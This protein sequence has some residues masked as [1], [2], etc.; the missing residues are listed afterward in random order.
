MFSPCSRCAAPRCRGGLRRPTPHGPQPPRHP[1]AT[2][3]ARRRRRPPEMRT[4]VVTARGNPDLSVGRDQGKTRPAGGRA[5][6]AERRMRARPNG[7]S[8]RRSSGGDAPTKSAPRSGC[9]SPTASGSPPTPRVIAEIAARSDV[10]SVRSDAS[11]WSRTSHPRSAN[12]ATIGAPSVWAD[13]RT[14]QGAVVAVL[15]SGVDMAHPDLASGFRGGATGW[16]DP[17]GQRPRRWTSAATA[18]LWPE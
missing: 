2:R 3:S 10:V 16:F 9:G 12:Q 1:L 4:V 5:Q 14:G 7:D 13:G 18:L 11:T 8:G 6:R 17:Y 15:D